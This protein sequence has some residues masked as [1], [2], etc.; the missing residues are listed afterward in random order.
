MWLCD[1]ACPFDLIS[2]E[3]LPPDL[4]QFAEQADEPATLA[5]ANGVVEADTTIAMQVKQL[6]DNIDPYLLDSTPDVLSV[7][8]RC[9]R[10]GYG[11]HWD[12]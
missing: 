11:F 8:R 2:R 4:E 5:T 9:V 7:G 3:T 10:E 6:E 12:P 1:T